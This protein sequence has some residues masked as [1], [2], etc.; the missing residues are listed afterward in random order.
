MWQHLKK[1]R[2]ERA[3][4]LGRMKAILKK[5]QDEKRDLTEADN[6]EFDEL[7]S[8]AEQRQ[9]EIERY[10]RAQNLEADLAIFV[11][12]QNAAVELRENK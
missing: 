3:D 4:A 2:E 10:E 1:L 6:K 5:S 7:N 9:Q 12:S 8:K 11:I